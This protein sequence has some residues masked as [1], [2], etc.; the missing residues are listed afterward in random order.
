MGE[1]QSERMSVP[2]TVAAAVAERWPERGPHWVRNA[3]GELAQLCTT[4]GAEPRRVLPARYGF[5]VVVEQHDS[6]CFIMRS[7]ADP[8]GPRQAR[9]LLRLA[10]LGASPRVFETF[11]TESATWTVM[12]AVQPGTPA[13]DATP[14]ELASVL[15]PLVGRPPDS[16]LPSLA[17]WLRLRLAN[18]AEDDLDPGKMPAT[19]A[20]RVDA[21]AA[22]KELTT[23]PTE[24]LCHGD[25]SPGN[26]LRSVEGLKL[27]DPRGVN[28]EV[29]Y[30]AAVAALKTRND[31]RLLADLLHIDRERVVAWFRIAVA[32]R[33]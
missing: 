17:G 18:G 32:A 16:G 25:T 33:V 27:V 12:D 20:E 31:P 19:R 14:D 3:P 7:T 24:S 9:V 5:V 23:E 30:D 26:V 29:A 8:D 2:K 28:G 22:L 21:L 11:E 6:R 4:Y 13:Y 15:H 1:T 10:A